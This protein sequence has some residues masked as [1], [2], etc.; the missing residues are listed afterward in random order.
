[1]IQST[2]GSLSAF[3]L[4]TKTSILLLVEAQ[5]RVKIF[6]A[7]ANCQG[8]Q[9][10]PGPLTVVHHV[11]FLVH[12]LVVLVHHV[13]ILA[14]HVVAVVS[15]VVAFRRCIVV[16]IIMLWLS[17]SILPFLQSRWQQ[18]RLLKGW[19]ILLLRNTISIDL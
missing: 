14:N 13:I 18:E 5:L 7:P 11:L 19:L 16:I 12:H 10:T 9:V 6:L 1:M 2:A 4:K 3:C 17:S 15:L 8:L